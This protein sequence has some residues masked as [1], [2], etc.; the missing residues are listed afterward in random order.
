M[1][2]DMPVS[3]ITVSV[4]VGKKGMTVK[5]QVMMNMMVYAQKSDMYFPGLTTDIVFGND[6]LDK[7]K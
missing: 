4:A 3:N 5:R 2:Y 1:L 7:N 6:W